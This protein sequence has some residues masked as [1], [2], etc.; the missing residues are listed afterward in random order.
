MACWY[1]L[2]NIENNR[3]NTE[4]RNFAVRVYLDITFSLIIL[5]G[6][7]FPGGVDRDDCSV[8]NSA[9]YNFHSVMKHGSKSAARYL[10][11]CIALRFFGIL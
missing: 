7:R 1:G 6:F 8:W 4:K 10:I 2:E 9:A 5:F 3:A 11:R